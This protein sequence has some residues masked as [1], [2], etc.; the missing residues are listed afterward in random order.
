MQQKKSMHTLAVVALFISALFWAT[1]YLFVKQTIEE[2]SPLYLLAFRY[3]LAAFFMLLIALPRL[4]QMSKGLLKS[5]IW[6][7]TALF[8]EFLT[9]T[10]GLQY[11]TAS[12][13]SF[14][15]AAYIIILPLVYFLVRRKLPKRQEILAAAVCM[16]GI[17]LIVTGGGGSVNKG[18]LIMFLC[19]VSYAFHIVFGGKF[20]KEYDGILLNLVQIGTTAVLASIVALLFGT[21]P[22][23]VTMPRAG[24]ILYLAAVATILP[25]LLCLFG[26]KYVSTTTS[27]IV[28]SFESVFATLMSI[29]F[30]NDQIS[31]QFALGGLLVIGAFFVSEWEPKKKQEPTGI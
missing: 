16:G 13:A 27:G 6:M 12:R 9:Y 10:L 29:L 26:Q 30:M 22:A 18:D 2:F 1:G 23:R 31:L 4:K 19:A 17:A 20:A 25:Y 28:L 15:V 3:L 11:T 5:G 14:I 8:F 21:W 24:S 7:G